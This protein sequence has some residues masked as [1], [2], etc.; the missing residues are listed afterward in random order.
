MK[1][2][3]YTCAYG[4]YPVLS[5]Y[6]DW[7]NHIR[8][9]YDIVPVIVADDQ[10]IADMCNDNKIVHLSAPNEPLGKKFNTVSLLK[11]ID[12]DYLMV[13]GSDDICNMRMIKYYFELMEKGLDF[14]GMKDI[15]IYG[16][17]PKQTKYWGGFKNHRIGETVGV[18][19]CLSRKLLDML[20]W[21]PWNSTLNSK[22]DRSM[23]EK[24]I[25]LGVKNHAMNLADSDCFLLDI[26]T[27]SNISKFNQ[28][29]GNVIASKQLYGY[30]PKGIVDKIL[31][32]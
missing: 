30:F 32:L 8:S 10:R 14:W 28:Y 13:M 4:R 15:Y 16:A 6:I 18:A 24:L 9:K 21:T 3:I 31:A 2:A 1:L 25:N 19:R 29:K 7:I 17:K 22:L 12:F 26:K 20:D 5:I 11:A 23:T 27:G